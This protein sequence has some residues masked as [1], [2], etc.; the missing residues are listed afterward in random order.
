MSPGRVETNFGV[1]DSTEQPSNVNLSDLPGI[2]AE[3]VAA[4]LIHIL[5]A[6]PHVQVRD[7]IRVNLYPVFYSI[8]IIEFY[9]KLLHAL[10]ILTLL[11]LFSVNHYVELL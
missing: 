7:S 4:T 11:S 2:K 6:P 5:S 10:S 9:I 3:D 8:F 1:P